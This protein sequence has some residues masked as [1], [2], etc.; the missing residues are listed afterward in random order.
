MPNNFDISDNMKAA[1]R[2]AVEDGNYKVVIKNLKRIAQQLNDGTEETEAEFAKEFMANIKEV[3]TP[4]MTTKF[5][6]YL[7]ALKADGMLVR[8]EWEKP[9]TDES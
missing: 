9:N 4:Q 6:Q 2:L 8:L 1:L 3:T 5:R 7:K